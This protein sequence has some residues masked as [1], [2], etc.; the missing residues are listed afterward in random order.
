MCFVI[1]FQNKFIVLKFVIFII[2]CFS[3]EAKFDF[4]M[5]VRF[6][7]EYFFKKIT[8]TRIYW[9]TWNIY[10]PNVFKFIIVREMIGTDQ[11]DFNEFYENILDN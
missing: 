4:N 5:K 1:D 7:F 9:I 6:Y 11:T 2:S 8:K 3:S 10:M